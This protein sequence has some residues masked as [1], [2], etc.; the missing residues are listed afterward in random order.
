MPKKP[1]ATDPE[2]P[3]A[4]VSALARQIMGRLVRTPPVPHEEISG[5][6]KPKRAQKKS[7]R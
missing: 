3:P 6:R 1:P 4:E 2:R 5:H 7:I